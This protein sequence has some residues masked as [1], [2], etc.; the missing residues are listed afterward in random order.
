MGQWDVRG[1]KDKCHKTATP[2]SLLREGEGE[3]K[4]S[5]SMESVGLPEAV[6]E[7]R[8]QSP[9]CLWP[10]QPCPALGRLSCRLL[11][12]CPGWLHM[13]ISLSPQH[14]SPRHFCALPGV[15]APRAAGPWH[16]EPW[17]EP[18]PAKGLWSRVVAAIASDLSNFDSSMESEH[19]STA[20][21]CPC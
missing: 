20:V 18:G 16:T 9:G 4:C 1:R 7:P 6:P 8:G 21:H 14:L 15:P 11:L 12:L 10:C 3:P 5:P 19:I 13:P 17:Q 2:A